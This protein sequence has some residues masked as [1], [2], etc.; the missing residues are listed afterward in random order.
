MKQQEIEYYSRLIL[1]RFK[2]LRPGEKLR[3]NSILYEARKEHAKEYRQIE[4]VLKILEM[5]RI[6]SEN[7]QA[8]L[9]LTDDGYSI[10][11]NNEIPVMKIELSAICNTYKS[12]DNLFYEVWEI[13]GTDEDNPYYVKGSTYFNAIRNFIPGLPATYTH[14]K[15]SLPLKDNGS[16]PSRLDWYKSL[17]QQLSDDQVLQFINYLSV[18]VNSNLVSFE[19]KGKEELVHN[20]KVLETTNLT[21]NI[22][23]KRMRS[24][25]IFIS[26]NTLDSA[27][28]KAIVELMAKIG[29]RYD[30]IFCSSYP[31]CGVIFG[32]G[33]LSAISKQFEEYNLFVLFI[34]SPRF[35]SS[36][37]SL[38]EMG[39]A[40]IL[41]S[42]HR[43]FLTSDCE[44]NMLK[45]VITSNEVAFKAGQ[46]NTYHLLHNF[47]N[48]LENFFNLPPIND[49]TWE[50][51]K[52]DFIKNVEAISNN[53]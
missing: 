9:S 52:N 32:N 14:F 23:V 2:G 27:Y 17:F 40:W 35:Y 15:D 20:T 12:K 49:A 7:G 8:F 11:N 3:K 41:K 30:D 34:H 46:D 36:A 51:I 6:I 33:I 42:D 38:N 5:N 4:I 53:Q 18:C 29:V 10:V 44:F 47:R 1:S 26:H 50:I 37:F 22:K 24:P 16:K 39:A 28:A 43:S 13:V 21:N 25:K 45:G 19:R 48:T 31:G